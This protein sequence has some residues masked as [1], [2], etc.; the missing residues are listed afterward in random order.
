MKMIKFK[1]Q[2]V[3]L[4]L[5]QTQREK[6]FRL[7]NKYFAGTETIPLNVKCS[8]EHERAAWAVSTNWRLEVEVMVAENGDITFTM[9]PITVKA[10]K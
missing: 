1:A 6:C 3:S 7:I 2:T 8:K 9:T 10:E 4:S 5:N